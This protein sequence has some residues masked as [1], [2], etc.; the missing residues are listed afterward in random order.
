MAEENIQAAK[1][2]NG[3]FPVCRKEKTTRKRHDMPLPEPLSNRLSTLYIAGYY[4]G[5]T[6][7]FKGVVILRKVPDIVSVSDRIVDL[8]ILVA[9][10]VSSGKQ[11]AQRLDTEPFGGMMSA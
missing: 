7:G 5:V 10:T 11:I 2:A 1:A 6:S 4:R 3:V 8:D 9:D